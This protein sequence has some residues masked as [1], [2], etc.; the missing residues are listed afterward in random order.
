VS[1]IYFVVWIK[2]YLCY[3]VTLELQISSHKVLNF[4]HYWLGGSVGFRAS[5]ESDPDGNSAFHKEHLAFMFSAFQACSSLGVYK[6]QFDLRMGA[7]K[8]LHVEQN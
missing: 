2:F 3:R 1:K 8:A 4:S 5:D 6:S 7:C